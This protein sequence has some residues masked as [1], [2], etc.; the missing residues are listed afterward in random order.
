MGSVDCEDSMEPPWHIN[1]DI[2]GRS[3]SFKLDSGADI[4]VMPE[5]TYKTL[6]HPPPLRRV[7]I[8]LG[9]LGGEI[10]AK[11]QFIA[12]AVANDRTFN[13]RDIV[14][15]GK[16]DNLLSRAAS[17]TMGLIGRLDSVALSDVFSNIG[18]MK[19][20]PVQIRLQENATQATYSLSAPRRIPIPILPK[21]KAEL[22]KMEDTGVIERVSE[23]TL[24]CSPL[25]PIIKKSGAIRI[26]VDLKR[27]K[28]QSH[29]IVWFCDRTIGCDLVSYDRSAMFAAISF[30][31]R[32]LWC[33]PYD[34][35]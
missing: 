12:R 22:E 33:I 24:W 14:V 31:N 30:Y 20:P 2:C 7:R 13:F 18:L 9:T 11:G 29:R 25:V 17:T 15:S 23:P 3:I 19:V 4:T 21:V 10:I 16:R 28:P 8:K 1:M 6:H 27:L 26:C 5:H 35:L 34:W 32:T